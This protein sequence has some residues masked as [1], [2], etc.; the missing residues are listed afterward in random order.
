M[1]SR[2]Y[3]R[4]SIHVPARPLAGDCHSP[5]AP[6]L[7]CCNAPRIALVI[8]VQSCSDMPTESLLKGLLSCAER[9]GAVGRFAAIASAAAANPQRLLSASGVMEHIT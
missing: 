8:S 2:W 3:V 7:Y 9:G 1:P 5:V 6:T 4:I